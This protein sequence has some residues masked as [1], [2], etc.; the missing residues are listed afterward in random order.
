MAGDAAGGSVATATVVSQV[1]ASLLALATSMSH[2]LGGTLIQELFVAAIGAG[3]RTGSAA[4]AA[5]CTEITSGI[6]I[7]AGDGKIGRASCRE[8]GEEAEGGA[9]R[10]QRKSG[11]G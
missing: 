2:G 1:E 7:A 11:S 6:A 10:A 9:T 4:G 5:S 3:A 8:R